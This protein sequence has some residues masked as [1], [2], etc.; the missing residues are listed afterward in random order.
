MEAKGEGGII[1]AH[2]SVIYFALY[3]CLVKSEPTI[4][5]GA[6]AAAGIDF[7]ASEYTVIVHLRGTW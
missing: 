7:S 2:F 1:A 5:L 4:R 6:F 3:F